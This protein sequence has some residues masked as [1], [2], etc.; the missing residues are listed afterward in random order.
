MSE[1]IPSKKLYEIMKDCGCKNLV[2]NVDLFKGNELLQWPALF[3][4]DE[5]GAYPD[6][7]DYY[8]V[9]AVAL[10]SFRYV[11]NL[12]VKSNFLRYLKPKLDEYEKTTRFPKP[13]IDIWK[14]VMDFWYERG[15][16]TK[17]D[18]RVQESIRDLARRDLRRLYSKAH[19]SAVYAYHVLRANPI[20]QLE[21]SLR[22]IVGQY[23]GTID[24]D[25]QISYDFLKKSL[26]KSRK[27]EIDPFSNKTY[28]NYDFLV[29]SVRRKK[30]WRDKME[31]GES[32]ELI[33]GVNDVE[34]YLYSDDDEDSPLGDAILR[35]VLNLPVD[36]DFDEEDDG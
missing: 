35:D 36:F 5:L 32:F 11:L 24:K 17:M 6:D 31:N 9:N 25:R 34:H 18:V 4:E 29:F 33:P 21:N 14:A 16:F 13:D 1:N 7:E 2:E 10:L 27:W 8:A 26:E 28:K 22:C 23:K 30:N 19:L 15:L 20:N 3:R 12:N